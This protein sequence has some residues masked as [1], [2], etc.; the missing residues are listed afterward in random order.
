M[1]FR[2][3]AYEVA[4]RDAR[5]RFRGPGF[6]A[7]TAITMVGAAAFVVA[8]R[9]TADVS[10]PVLRIA[11][12]DAEPIT[13]E[14]AE[15]LGAVAGGRVRL[16]GVADRQAAENRLRSGDLAVAVIGDEV[17]V[18]RSVQPDDPSP[19]ARLAQSLSTFLA[20]RSNPPLE[21]Q[22]LEPGQPGQLGRRLN[23]MFAEILI[24]VFILTYGNWVLGGVVEEKG[25]R[26]AE[27]LLGSVR[28]RAML[29]G[30]V[31]GTGVVAVLQA[32]M[33]GLAVAA[34]ALA[35]GNNV[36]GGVTG[37]L[38]VGSLLW[39]LLGYLFYAMAYAAAGSTVQSMTESGAVTT[40][41][42]LPLI[43]G[44]VVVV[45]TIPA[46]GDSAVTTILS[47]LPPT[48][49]MAMTARIGMGTVTGVEVAISA[50]LMVA[51]IMGLVRFAGFVYSR[52]I[53]R[54]GQRVRIRGLLRE[55]SA[56]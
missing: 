23:A 24:F 49:P 21:I 45:S 7:L 44:H 14:L 1:T 37:R 51:S 19:E 22:G 15:Q 12:I 53:L 27:V 38:I 16:V 5:E 26:I 2:R 29:F 47:F 40:P 18:H 30:K 54:T 8:P 20:L 31:L 33:I 13:P 43:A 46:V 39:F 3:S 50:V 55:R 6:W 17:V 52:S 42:Q 25:S 41:I 56:A 10:Q 11:F 9:V 34:A 32:S 36:F 4:R 48:A 35:V 28:P